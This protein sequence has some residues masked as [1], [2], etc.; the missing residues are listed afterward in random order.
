MCGICG[1]NWRDESLL[2]RMKG[3]IRH[4]G[5]DGEGS[6][7][8][9]RASLGHRR[10]SIVDLSDN[11]RQPLGNEDGTLWLTFNGEIYNHRELRA[12]LESRGHSFRSRTDSEVIVHAYEEYG[13]DCVKH[14]VRMFAYALWD[15]GRRRF[16]LARD[17]LGIK[18]LYYA[19]RDGRLL[20]ASEIKAI[21]CD[22][23]VPRRISPQ[24]LHDL[25]GYEF[26]PA[27]ATLLEDVHKLLPGHILAVEADGRPRISRFWSLE[28]KDVDATP[29]EFLS[30]LETVCREHLM[31]DVPIGAFLSGGIDSSTVVR[32][33]TQFMD[34]PLST[35][36]LG[37]AEATFSEFEHARRVADHFR[38]EHHELMIRPVDVEAIRKSIW[39]LDEP[40]TDLSN[41]PF[42]LICEQAAR[43]VKVC[44]SG[45]G[46]DELLMGYDRFRA[47]RAAH[48]LEALP[49]PF[50]NS[51]YRALIASI[52]DNERKKGARNVLKRFLQGAVLSPEGEHMRWQYFLHPGEA[53]RLFR[54]ELFAQVDP[55]PFAPVARWSRLAPEERG[56]REQFVEINTILPDS[57]LMKVDKMSM[58]YGL[59]VRPPLLDHRVVEYCYSLPTSYK[60][61]RFETK[62]LFKQAVADL[63]PPGIAH[64]KKEGFSLPIKNW[65]RSDLAEVAR[66]EIFSS[67]TIA[68]HFDPDGLREIWE[69]HQSRRHNH[70]HLLWTLLNLALWSRMFLGRGDA[71]QERA[72][73]VRG[74]SGC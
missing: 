59:E 54:P 27:P 21:L 65:L 2:E 67:A 10:L 69:Q 37:Y 46:G 57:V 47:S 51:L 40:T 38:T 4:R 53:R 23:D 25:M 55:D 74:V 31:S 30:L 15:G 33:L 20:F 12:R 26:V 9:D 52:G 70:S 6:Y 22:R 73:A 68:E 35:F 72:P 17:R 39:H 14:L 71:A 64:R 56:K 43:S 61:R 45:D 5:P 24:A 62:W 28:Q 50:R 36:S 48:L 41:L 29:E 42:M 60:L 34:T 66:D 19:A 3:T 11:G 1:F 18:P 13:D 16:L 58:A 8:D 7:F 44:L 32:F 49:I 63:L